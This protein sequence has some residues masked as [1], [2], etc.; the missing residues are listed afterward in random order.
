MPR[1]HDV[2]IVEYPVARHRNPADVSPAGVPEADRAPSRLPGL[3]LIARGAG[4]A[5]P[6]VVAAP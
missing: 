6:N 4:L 2:D 5:A 1:Q 3:F